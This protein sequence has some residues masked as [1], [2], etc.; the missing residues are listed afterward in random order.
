MPEAARPAGNMRKR[1]CLGAAAICLLAITVMLANPFA[2]SAS[3][4]T[5]PIVY[6][7]EKRVKLLHD[8]LAPRTGHLHQG[9]DLMTAKMTKEMA[10]VSGTVSLRVG[11]VRGRALVLHLAGR[12]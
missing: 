12:R 1:A 3:A 4:T 9:T 6:P 10:C 7:L 8:Y 11:D 5:V 2:S